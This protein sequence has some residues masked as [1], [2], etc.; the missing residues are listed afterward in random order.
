[1][2]ADFLYARA[3]KNLHSNVVLDIAFLCAVLSFVPSRL[4]LN[5]VDAHT[6]KLNIFPFVTPETIFDFFVWLCG[7]LPECVCAVHV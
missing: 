5:V 2:E 1:M 3:R 4:V 6:I 7:C